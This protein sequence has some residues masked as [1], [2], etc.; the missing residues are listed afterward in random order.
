MQANTELPSAPAE[1]ERGRKGGGDNSVNEAKW[2]YQV[3]IKSD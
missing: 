2:L 1:G 3:H